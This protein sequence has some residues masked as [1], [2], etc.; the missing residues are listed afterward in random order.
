MSQ[1]TTRSIT[2]TSTPTPTRQLATRRDWAA[3][4]VLMLP[5][6]LVSIDNTVLSFAI[7]TISREFDASGAMLLWIVDVYPLVLA[8]LLVAMGSLGDRIGRRRLLM[9]GGTGFAV[10]SVVAANAGSAQELVGARAGLGVF[11]AMLMPATLSLLRNTFLDRQQRRLALAIWAGGFAAGSALGPVVGGFL[12]E[13]YH[14]G[15]VFLLAVPVLAVMLVATPIFVSE[16]KDPEPGPVDLVSVVLSIATLAPVVYAIKQFAA[17]GVT[18]TVVAGIGFGVG[19]GVWFVWRQLARPNPM[20]DVRLFAYAP[21]SGAVLVNFLAIFSLVGFLYFG[22]QH[23]QLVLELGPMEAGLY[24]LPGMAVTMTAGLVA[25]RLVRRVHVSVIIAVALLCSAVGYGLIAVIGDGG[26]A[27]ALALA[28]CVLSA[29]VGAS[30]TLSNDVIISA[31]P[32]HKAGAA[33]AV[34]ETAYEVGAVMGTAVLGSILTASYRAAIDLPVGLTQAQQSVASETLGGALNVAADLTGTA[35]EQLVASAQ[36]AF[37]TGVVWTSVIGAAL[38]LLAAF[39][40]HRTLRD[41]V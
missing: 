3:L 12:L 27:L 11:G 15:S 13:H 33:S 4:V 24:L 20:L 29:G 28:F 18:G 6:L 35:A 2:P 7:P 17:Y 34:S 32:A 23:L 41:A 36:H 16:S 25:V 9:I 22:S 5:V 21:F 38:M 39:V 8:A 1:P 19:A 10:L 30:E 14:W 37:D 26:T 31:V 40:A